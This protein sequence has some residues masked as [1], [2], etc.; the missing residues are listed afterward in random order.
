MNY[1]EMDVDSQ[2]VEGLSG[3]EGLDMTSILQ[4]VMESES[5]PL[6]ALQDILMTMLLPMI[7]LGVILVII[8]IVRMVVKM[9]DRRDMK[10]MQQ[11]IKAIREII[12]KEIRLRTRGPVLPTSSEAQSS[13]DIAHR[14]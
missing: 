13:T 7:I 5:S 6:S 1:D 12:E 8:L 10:A 11:D 14:Q 3:V 9:R 2:M 4:Q